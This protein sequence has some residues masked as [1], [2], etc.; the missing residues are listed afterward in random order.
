M[1]QHPNPS[2]REWPSWPL[3]F[4]VAPIRP[5]VLPVDF[6]TRT[7]LRRQIREIAEPLV[8][9]VGCELIAVDLTGDRG[10]PILRLSIDRAGGVG[11]GDCKKVSRALSLELDVED[12][13]PGAYRLEVSSPGIDRPVERDVDF[14]R[15]V[16]FRA[17][18]RMDP[19]WGRRRYKGELAGLED[20]HVL[21]RATDGEHR[22]PRTRIDRVQLDLTVDDFARLGDPFADLHPDGAPAAPQGGSR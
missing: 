10:G 2:P 3:P 14:E 6:E 17:R 22:L 13:M 1:R 19:E 9:D 12:P 11:V 7:S 4:F 15:F 8:E 16:G 18:V 20:G 5:S 21:L